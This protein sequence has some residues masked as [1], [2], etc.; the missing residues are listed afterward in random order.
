MEVKRHK[1]PE[2]LNVT[3]LDHEQDSGKLLEAD[4]KEIKLVRRQEVEDALGI[5]RSTLYRLLAAENALPAPVTLPGGGVRWVWSEIMD[6]A[7]QRIK[8]RGQA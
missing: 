2:A 1:T 8:E 3:S 7:Q 6:W 4:Q 5:S